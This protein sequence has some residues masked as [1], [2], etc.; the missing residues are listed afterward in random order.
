M[1]ETNKNQFS[2]QNFYK[3]ISEFGNNLFILINWKLLTCRKSVF[4]LNH[5]WFIKITSYF[6]I[7]Y[8]GIRKKSLGENKSC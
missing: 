6:K 5:P 1:A 4:F 8:E 7:W 3:Q 2:K